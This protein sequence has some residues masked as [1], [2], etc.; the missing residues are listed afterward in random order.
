MP[1]AMHT[2]DRNRFSGLLYIHYTALIQCTRM[3][4]TLFGIALCSFYN[5]SA[6][7]T[8]DRNH[9]SGLLYVHYTALI[10]CAHMNETL[11]W[12]VSCSLDAMPMHN[13]NHLSVS[14]DYVIVIS[15]VVRL[16]VEI[17]HEL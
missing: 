15:W 10:Q 17:I 13:R 3:I 6:I 5:P 16:Y 2:D 1:S 11:F 7:H 14:H 8:H 9:L 4:E 12:I